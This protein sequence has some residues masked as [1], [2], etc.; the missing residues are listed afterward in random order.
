MKTSSLKRK[1]I[2]FIVIIITPIVSS[3]IVSV[4]LSKRINDNYKSMLNKLVVTNEIKGNLN[5]S[6]KD[7]NNFIQMNNYNSKKTFATKY[8][9]ILSEK[10][11]LEQDSDLDSQYILRDLSNSLI[12]FKDSA[13]KT[14][15]K[16]DNKDGIDDYYDDFVSAKESFNY[17]NTIINKL[18]DNYIKYNNNVYVELKQKEHR[19]Y[20]VIIIYILVS[21]L[22]SLLYSLFFIKNILDKIYELV[23]ASKKVSEGNFLKYEGNKSY[24]YELDILSEAFSSMI[25]YIS[26]YINSLKEKAELE[27][28]LRNEEMEILEYEN[29]LKQSQLKILQSQINPH[30]LFNTLNCINQ[31][32]IKEKAEETQVLIISVSEILRYSLSMMNKNAFLQEE[33]NV[34]NQYMYIQKTRF[35]DKIKFELIVKGDISN[36]RVPGMTLQPFV[37]NAFIHGI[38]PKEGDGVI[39]IIIDSYDDFCTIII[40]DNGCGINDDILKKIIS[41]EFQQEHIGHTTGMGIRSVVKRLEILYNSKDIFSIESEKDVGT[42]IYLKIPNRR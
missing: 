16:Y 7:F 19:L 35:K 26:K 9:Q 17:C 14:I 24:I 29:A 41:E 1:F 5:D 30:F 36:I 11:T 10:N 28:K 22:I 27:L 12:S 25:A 33:I 39:K 42:R 32:A 13:D 2:I 34:V 4:I 21:L 15:E 23:N 40:E 8:G 18:S 31:T 38:E 6:F 3:T 37:E 20:I